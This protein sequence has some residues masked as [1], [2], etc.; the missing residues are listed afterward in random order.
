M[1]MTDARSAA[2]A[3][4][5]FGRPPQE[6][7]ENRDGLRG[8]RCDLPRDVACF[9]QSVTGR[10]DKVNESF[11]VGDSS[12]G[13]RFKVMRCRF[14]LIRFGTEQTDGWR[15]YDRRGVGCVFT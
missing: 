7:A 5:L 9:G 3:R 12:T 2:N 11:L 14:G 6:P 8:Q 13:V 1:R 4:A 10:D 15:G